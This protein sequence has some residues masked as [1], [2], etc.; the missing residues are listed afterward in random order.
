[1][2]EHYKEEYISLKMLGDGKKF[3]SENTRFN[4]YLPMLPRKLYKYQSFQDYTFDMLENRYQF[5]APASS[6]DDP[7]DCLTNCNLDDL[8]ENKSGTVLEAIFSYIIELLGKHCYLKKNLI[9][10]TLA[11]L[12]DSLVNGEIN[13]EIL[14]GKII[15]IDYIEDEDKK[16][17]YNV[18]VNFDKAFE[19][20]FTNENYKKQFGLLYN[21]KKTIGI[22][23]LTTKKD[24]KPMWSLYGNNYRGFVIEYCVPKSDEVIQELYPVLYKKKQDCNIIKVTLEFVVETLIRFISEGQRIT[25]MNCLNTLM[26]TK[27][28]DWEFQDEWRLIGNPSDKVRTLIQSCVYLGCN[29][30][31]VNEEKM[32]ECASKDYFSVYKMNKPNGNMKISY[33]KLI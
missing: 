16:L 20:V 27:D 2:N 29:V 25:N 13:K 22:C 24:N 6:L 32:I 8:F 9:M 15:S 23:S 18:L 5:L 31:K 17:F 26:C 28:L 14:K 33:R 4:K 12:K 3:E 7:F 10:K 30:E 11:S 1:M 19:A 21:S